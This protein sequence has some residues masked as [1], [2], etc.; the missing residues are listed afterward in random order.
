MDASTKIGTGHVMRCLTLADALKE[1]D[2]TSIHFICRQ[3]SDSL[4]QM[5]QGR[6]FEL[7]ILPKGTQVDG[8]SSLAHASWLGATQA[9]DANA[10]LNLIKNNQYDWLIVDHYALDIHWER[11]IK[12]VVKKLMVIDDLADR[13]HDCDLLLDQNFYS[14][15]DTRY[16]GKVPDKCKALLGP[17]YALL[18]KEFA[19]YR[20]QTKPRVGGVKR[21]LV[22]WGGVDAND[23]TSKTIKALSR[24][25]SQKFEVDVVIGDQHPNK[26]GVVALCCEYGFACHVQTERMADLMANADFAIGAGGGAVWERACLMLPTLSLPIAQHQRKQL[27]DIALA[28]LVYTIELE[29]YPI[30]KIK[31]HIEGLIENKALRRLLSVRSAE[32]VDGKGAN[33]VVKYL[34]SEMEIHLR[35]ATPHDE[36]ALFEWRN[37]QKIREISFNKHEIEWEQHCNWFNALLSDNNR[38]L[39]IGEY[40]N[41]PV[42]VVRFD[43]DNDAAE[44]SIYLIQDV[45]NEGLGMPLLRSAEKWICQHR[46]EIKMLKAHVLEG[47]QVSHKFFIKAGF[48]AEIRAYYK[49]L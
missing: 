26:E 37:H 24:I 42:G 5:I 36:Q 10:T 40:K 14:D 13:E 46:T 16:V 33:R 1:S 20:D 22:F 34:R 11:S 48:S 12:P 18:R 4:R 31:S 43:L 39:L 28:G 21:I 23:F 45:G 9:D 8:E 44:V 30:E 25:T 35:K 41:K 2:D 29:D 19:G 3:V 32:M 6:G 15:M 17:R 7:S 47:N 38:V 49:K 27:E